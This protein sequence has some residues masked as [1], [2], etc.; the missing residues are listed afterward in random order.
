MIIELNAYRHPGGRRT[1]TQREKGT[2]QW[3]DCK[4]PMT[5]WG[6]LDDA[7]FFRAVA[8]HIG[9]LSAEGHIVHYTDN[10]E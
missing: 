10:G 8:N 4:E 5:L 1:L 9:K 6:S 7:S 2:F 3:D